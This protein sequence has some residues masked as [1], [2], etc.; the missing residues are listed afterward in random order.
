MINLINLNKDMLENDELRQEQEIL[1][2]NLVGM[3]PQQSPSG[4]KGLVDIL[5]KL[6]HDSFINEC[7][8]FNKRGISQEG[9][10]E[11]FLN[12]ELKELFGYIKEKDEEG[13]INFFSEKDGNFFKRLLLG[14][15]LSGEEE[16]FIDFLYS[17]EVIKGLSSD[18]IVRF[19]AETFNTEG[20]VGTGSA[21]ALPQLFNGIRNTILN[22]ALDAW[23]EIEE[24]TAEIYTQELL[25]KIV[26]AFD[27][28]ELVLAT[29]GSPTKGSVQKR[30]TETV[31]AKKLLELEYGI[32]VEDSDPRKLFVV[33]EAEKAYF[34]DISA[35]ARSAKSGSTGSTKAEINADVSKATRKALDESM[36]KYLK[37]KKV[38]LSEDKNASEYFY[39]P[40]FLNS[41]EFK[42]IL[43]KLTDAKSFIDQKV[44]ES[45][46]E[47]NEEKN[48]FSS[49]SEFL[50][51]QLNNASGFN[52][53]KEYW[54]NFLNEPKNRDFIDKLNKW[55]KG[56]SNGA[57]VI[58]HI[59]EHFAKYY[60]RNSSTIFG[61][62]KNKLGQDAHVDI[63]SLQTGFQVKNYSGTVN[64]FHFYDSDT[65]VFG[66][67]I[68]RYISPNFSIGR[69]EIVVSLRYIAANK[70]ILGGNEND[71]SNTIKNFLE[72]NFDYWTRYDDAESNFDELKGM[73]NNFFVLNF[74]LIP[75]SLIFQQLINKI[76]EA[77]KEQYF[78]LDKFYMQETDKLEKIYDL[79]KNHQDLNKPHFGRVIFKGFRFNIADLANTK[80]KNKKG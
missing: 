46:G 31:S 48:N 30:S 2:K 60:L 15:K 56:Y 38:I 35:A 8:Y 73:K 40:F 55:G 20:Y 63:G 29:T 6:R 61:Q 65:S 62:N 5:T 26:Q 78:N 68:T 34:K 16:N 17:K 74:K 23:N 24:E 49:F 21:I 45:K 41:D 64:S 14:R 50:T 79:S 7:K 77:N 10:S 57:N 22:E 58:G 39:T 80:L 11:D 75:A 66:R 76:D 42:K 9:Y 19:D 18:M 51:Y 12:E 1:Y 70:N 37:D 27:D 44:Q 47:V 43:S 3:I 52:D 28:V 36:I 32:Y 67:T 71:V 33:N 54:N 25:K 59:G 69:E 72:L 4:K 53:A 13:Y